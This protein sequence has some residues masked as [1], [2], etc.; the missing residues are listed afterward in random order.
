MRQRVPF[1]QGVRLIVGLMKG[2]T[3]AMR[4]TVGETCELT[5]TDRG[6]IP[7]NSLTYK[8]TS[9]HRQRVFVIAEEL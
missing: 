2:R 8:N 6:S 5:F 3:T 4:F 7:Q 9:G 1:W